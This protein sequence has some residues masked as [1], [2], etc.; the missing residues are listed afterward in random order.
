MAAESG[1]VSPS[2]ST[3]AF[4]PQSSSCISAGSDDTSD[5]ESMD[6]QVADSSSSKAENTNF[7]AFRPWLCD[8]N[9]TNKSIE[10]QIAKPQAPCKCMSFH[11]NR[12]ILN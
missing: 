10:K 7:N 5:R 1:F 11:G 2:S 6:V 3:A 8:S 4:S 9:S 12:Y